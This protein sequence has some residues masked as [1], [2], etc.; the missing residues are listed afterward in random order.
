MA[1]PLR[2]EFPGAWYHLTARGNERRAIFRSDW[3][4]ERF[5]DLLGELR[6]RFEVRIH[7][8]VLMS[9][10]YHLIVETAQGQLSRA[11]HWL[12][13]SY[14]VWFNR[15]HGRSG[16]LFQG[17]FKGILLDVEEHGAA[18][19]RYVHLNPVRLVRFGLGKKQRAQSR[20]GLGVAATR[21]AVSERRAALRQFEWSS[22]RA[23]IGME[24]PQ[25]WL[26]VEELRAMVGGP[27]GKAAESYRRYVEEA[28]RD[29]L[30]ESPLE[31]VEAQLVLGGAAL[32]SR[33]RGLLG[34]ERRREQP[35]AR[36][37]GRRDFAGVVAV[38]SQ[39]KGEA[40]ENFRDR[41]GDW[42]RDLALWLGRRHCG[43]QLREL[44]ELAGGLDYA[45]V[46]VATI[47]WQNRAAAARKLMK[48]QREAERLLNAET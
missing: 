40:W 48:I 5:L 25:S 29:G 6:V 36:S 9:N 22:Y 24:K 21:E 45:T 26:Y 41:Y 15:R 13:V 34:G 44:G 14:T 20:A 32:L 47:R 39:L 16:H 43:L 28:L 23:Y 35:G 17:R 37:L 3:D 31:E 11:L 19:S 18:L 8:Y 38:V 1:R 4:R 7:A 10:H 42:G 30:Q 33:V 12:N 27:R 46:S 2:V